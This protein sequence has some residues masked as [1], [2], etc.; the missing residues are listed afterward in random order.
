MVV[1]H[2]PHV[3]A[4]G[5]V[6]AC[7]CATVVSCR[8]A[9]LHVVCV[10]QQSLAV[11]AACTGAAAALQSMCTSCPTLVAD[12]RVHHSLSA[13]L[14]EAVRAGLPRTPHLDVVTALVSVVASMPHA[15]GCAAVLVMV[16]D[17]AVRL[18]GAVS[19][20]SAGRDTALAELAAVAAM[21]HAL[22]VVPPSDGAADV[23][24]FVALRSLWDTLTAV[25]G[26]WLTDAAVAEAL[27]KV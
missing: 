10:S 22:P 5:G 14:S 20:G 1:T 7:A 9:G 21:F 13:A 16:K 2:L 26:A 6:R 8:V 19:A 15:A 25:A 4:A 24:A 18:Q 27:V 23:P 12:A 17:M 3:L 11:P